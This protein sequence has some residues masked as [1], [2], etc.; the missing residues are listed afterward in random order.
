MKKIDDKGISVSHIDHNQ[1]QEK[2]YFNRNEECV[3]VV[4]YYNKS[5]KVTKWLVDQNKSNSDDLI[6]TLKSIL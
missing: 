4:F 5:G 1:Y 2:Y 6:E 3:V